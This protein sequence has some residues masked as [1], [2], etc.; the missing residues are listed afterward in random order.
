MTITGKVIQGLQ[1]GRKLGYPT[2]NLEYESEKPLESG[3]YAS[4]VVFDSV[5]YI[6]ALVIGGNFKTELPLKFEVYLLDFEGDLYGEELKVCVLDKVRNLEQ[7]ESREAL[8][9]QI[10]RDIIA[11]RAL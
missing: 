9:E 8:I 7:F 3:V 10:E 4:R 11:I 1:E 2:A 5:E 6:G